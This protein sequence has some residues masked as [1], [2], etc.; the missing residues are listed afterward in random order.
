M[1]ITNTLT[2]NKLDPWFVTLCSKILDL[3]RNYRLWYQTSPSVLLLVVLLSYLLKPTF[4]PISIPKNSRIQS[5][6]YPECS[7]LNVRMFDLNNYV[8]TDSRFYYKNE[9]KNR[10]DCQVNICHFTFIAK[11][12]ISLPL[13]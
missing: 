11:T 7:R 8:F 9:I 12:S 6:P 5:Q 1:V 2:L 13:S 4:H 3:H 10:T